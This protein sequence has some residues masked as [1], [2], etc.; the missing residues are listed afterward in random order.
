M[1]PLSTW[2]FGM[3]PSLPLQH[4]VCATLLALLPL[5]ALACD[6]ADAAREAAYRQLPE[7]ALPT[8][9]R[10]TDLDSMAC[11]D[12][13]AM[14]GTTLLAVA[15][16]DAPASEDARGGDLDL[17][18][19]DTASRRPLAWTRIPDAVSS[20]AM[21]FTGLSLDTA[22][23][24]LAPGTRAFG[25]RMSYSGS[26]G[27]N[28][29]GQTDL[30]LFVRDGQELRQVMPALAVSGSNGEWDT[31]CAGTFSRFQRTLEMGQP[32]AAARAPILVRES[33]VDS[34][35]TERDG[36]CHTDETTRPPTRWSMPASGARYVV[37]KALR[38][39]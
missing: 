19:L 39:L 7:G 23:W 16:W 21:R 31:R 14:P 29:F 6:D 26:S 1:Q 25:V 30:Q 22:R 11:R 2:T 8:S 4:R 12:W 5:P 10:H 17:L 24:Q 28:P 27:P 35:S 20:D 18:L 34:V 13:A 33:R 38:G 15:Q 37:P 36:Q 9:A 3:R 32:G